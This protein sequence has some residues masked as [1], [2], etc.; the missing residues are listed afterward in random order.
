MIR[1]V[2]LSKEFRGESGAFRALGTLDLDVAAREFFV[3]LGPSGSGKTTLLRSIAGIETPDQG[4]I[5]LGDRLIFSAAQQINVR[6]EE[7]GLGMVFQS[8]AVWPHMTVY[9]NVALPLLHGA[10]RI[11]RSRVRDRVMHALAMVQ[12]ENF[13]DR[14]VPLLSGGQQQRVALA[15]ALAV[16]PLVLLMDEPLSNLDA[17]LREEV[18]SQ[19]KEVTNSVGVTVLY[20]TH[21][22]AEAAS[23]A[24]RVAVMSEGRILQ[25]ATP[26][27]LYRTPSAPAVAD[28][29]GRVN[30]LQGTI[31]NRDRVET[32]IGVLNAKTGALSG[33]VRVALRPADIV[34][35]QT[36][37]GGA[38][39]F[40]G[41]VSEE[42][43][44]GEQTHVRLLL[45]HGRSIDVKLFTRVKAPLNGTSVFFR[46]DPDDILV[47]P[48]EPAR[49]IS[50]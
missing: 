47:F 29:L 9:Q 42:V 43:F 35:S 48:N 23:L 44:L 30:W 7:R 10:R 22:Q 17:R 25:I 31:R 46:C 8:Y 36:A 13:A 40:E 18:R 28:F 41:R 19:I 50:D 34:I 14:P 5:Y 4:D 24:D 15:R 27:E 32:E 49:R 16:Q 3:L 6:P 38:N 45:Q 33:A 12:M 1:V 2:G 11:D 20:V 39:E 26:D 21:D 37:S